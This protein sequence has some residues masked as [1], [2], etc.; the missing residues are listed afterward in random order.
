[1]SLPTEHLLTT[2]QALAAALT[3][4]RQAAAGSDPIDEELFRLAIVKGFELS[5]EICFKLLRRR[6]RDI[7]PGS[8]RLAAMPVKDVLRL[9][10]HYDL[11]TLDEVE[12]WF[13]YRDNRND[14][15][16]D[17]GEQFAQQTLSLLEAYLPD[18]RA[19]A[20]R[21]QQEEGATL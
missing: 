8:S 18:A 20:L 21:L 5:Q 2:L 15:A 3:R 16:H 17:Y 14:T 11:L 12:R 6:L 1:M 19:L 13:R 4:Y 7:V 10:A 9:A